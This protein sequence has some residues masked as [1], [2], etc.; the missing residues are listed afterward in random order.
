M[1]GVKH[2]RRWRED[3]LRGELC[4]PGLVAVHRRR[5]TSTHSGT[6]EADLVAPRA[7]G[8]RGHRGHRLA[9]D[10][11]TEEAVGRRSVA[12]RCPRRGWS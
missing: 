3:A 7:L 9:M 11:A 10:S 6:G 4:E 12:V 5:T 2:A 1:K 8:H